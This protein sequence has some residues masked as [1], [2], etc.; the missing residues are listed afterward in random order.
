MD[1]D[2]SMRIWNKIRV[3]RSHN[4]KIHDSILHFPNSKLSIKQVTNNFYFFNITFLFPLKISRKTY[5]YVQSVLVSDRTTSDDLKRESVTFRDNC[6]I[7]EGGGN[8]SFLSLSL[9]RRE[10]PFFRHDGKI[11]GKLT[12]SFLRP[13]EIR[14]TR[15]LCV[16]NWQKEPRDSAKSYTKFRQG[17]REICRV[18]EKHSSEH[19]AKGGGE[20]GRE[21]SFANFTRLV[22]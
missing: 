14:L 8:E 16:G 18:T 4:W 6:T 15:E 17:T 10:H 21:K 5:Q 7:S 20:E 1:I 13:R 3:I 2:I 12:P 19:S 9:S 11:C 22:E